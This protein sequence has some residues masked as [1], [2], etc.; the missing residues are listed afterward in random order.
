LFVP[1]FD[2]IEVGM[3]EVMLRTGKQ[4]NKR[5]IQFVLQALLALF[6]KYLNNYIIFFILLCIIFLIIISKYTDTQEAPKSLSLCSSSS[7]ESVV[8]VEDERQKDSLLKPT[9]TNA[10]RVSGSNG[11]GAFT[12][13]VR[14]RGE[15]DGR[16][17]SDAS[18]QITKVNKLGLTFL[19]NFKLK[20][21]VHIIVFIFYVNVFVLH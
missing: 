18:T 19:K 15:P 1:G 12:S 3:D 17:A 16:T 2:L 11:S 13:Y 6:G 9:S 10:L 5:S 14:K 4:A 7:L 21:N 8:T 20:Y